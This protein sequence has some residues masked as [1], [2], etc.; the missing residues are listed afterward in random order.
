LKAAFA[1][2][3]PETAWDAACAVISY[4]KE[5]IDDAAKW[6][7]QATFGTTPCDTCDGL[8]IGPGVVATC[9]Q[10]KRC[11]YGPVRDDVAHRRVIDSL[12]GDDQE[13]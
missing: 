2:G 3:N 12:L 9:F 4:S 5:A 13:F 1:T 10:V 7:F 8:H 6:R 11:T